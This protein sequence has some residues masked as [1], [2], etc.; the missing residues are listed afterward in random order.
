MVLYP[1]PIP[2]IDLL[3]SYDMV[4]NP[5]SSYPVNFLMGNWKVQ[6]EGSISGMMIK[7]LLPD[8]RFVQT[9]RFDWPPVVFTEHVIEY[10]ISKDIVDMLGGNE[11]LY[12]HKVLTQQNESSSILFTITRSVLHALW[13][14]GGKA[15]QLLRCVP[16]FVWA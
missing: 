10:P 8:S 3:A 2:I 1:L 16:S 11:I 7:P 9:E 4:T 14:K 5:K 12:F 6:N 15:T 13:C